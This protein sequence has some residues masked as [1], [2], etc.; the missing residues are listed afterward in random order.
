[1]SGEKFEE[2]IQRLEKIVQNL[3][4][5]ELSLEESLKDFDEGMKLVKLC[6]KRLEEAE[7]KVNILIE[8]SNG[9]LVQAPFELEE[10][11]T[12]NRPTDD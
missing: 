10:K 5:G 4:G 11:E 1:M 7:K 12:K 3:E 2:S 9:K 8:E 6:S